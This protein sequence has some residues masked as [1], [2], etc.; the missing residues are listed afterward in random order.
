M[1]GAREAQE[2]KGA[3]ARVV[4]RE[5]AKGKEAGVAA[6]QVEEVREVQ[7]AR[8]AAATAVEGWAMEGWEV[9]GREVKG[10]AGEG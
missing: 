2:A 3:W 6:G 5:G 4:A 8:V 9:A 7:E 10:W 1:K